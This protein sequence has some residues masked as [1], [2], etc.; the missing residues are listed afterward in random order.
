M[1]LTNTQLLSLGFKPSVRGRGGLSKVKKYDSLVLPLNDSDFL[2][3]GYNP[4]KNQ[5]NYKTIW[6]SFKDSE[7]NRI[8]YQV[9]NLA[10]TGF[11]ELKE[12]I[13]RTIRNQMLMGIPHS[14]I[15]NN[16][17][18]EDLVE[19]MVN[20]TKEL[21]HSSA[22][23]ADYRSPSAVQEGSTQANVIEVGDNGELL[24]DVAKKVYPEALAKNGCI[25]N[26]T[27]EVSV[28]LEP[29]KDIPKIDG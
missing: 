4:Y 5:V 13:Y 7:G 1:A 16:I 23:I 19:G 3:T 18:P 14:I 24:Q 28:D 12:Y 17:L 10:D 29:K 6:K 8:T 9:I 26:R 2:Y 27:N 15:E 25:D 21:I 11:G 20:D 22:F